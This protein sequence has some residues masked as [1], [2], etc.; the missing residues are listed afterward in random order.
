MVPPVYA[1]SQQKDIKFI[2]EHIAT[3]LTH[4]ANLSFTQGIFPRELKYKWCILF[5]IP[6]IPWSF[7]LPSL[8]FFAVILFQDSWKKV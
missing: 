4:L 1:V 8:N 3:P 7:Q 2:A 6:R 5:T